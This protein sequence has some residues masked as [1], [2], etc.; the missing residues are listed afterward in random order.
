MKRTAKNLLAFGLVLFFASA[1]LC[2]TLAAP[3]QSLASITGCSHDNHAMEMAGCEH[4]SYLCSFNRS[5]HL[6]SEGSRSWA[7]SNDSLKNTLGVAVGEACFEY[8]A[9]GGELV[10]NE[11]KH[12][13]PIGPHKVSI[14]LFNSVLNL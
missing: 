10:W 1:V 8:S 6:L 2:A 13:L 11:H 5:S 9:Y 4:P 12:A 7:R 14:H 3:G